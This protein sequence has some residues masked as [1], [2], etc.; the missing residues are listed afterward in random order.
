M[1]SKIEAKAKRRERVRKTIVGTAERPRLSLFRSL[2]HLTGQLI[3]DSSGRTLLGLST[4]AKDHKKI[5]AGN[6]KGAKQFGLAF[7]KMAVAKNFKKI[8]FD[9]GGSLFHG[10]V[11]AFADGAREGGLEF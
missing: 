6:V 11:K 3:D 2:K 8:L 4:V 9:R 1:R 7:A 5:K 10:R